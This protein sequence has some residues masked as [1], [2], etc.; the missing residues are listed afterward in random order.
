MKSLKQKSSYTPLYIYNMRYDMSETKSYLEVDYFTLSFIMIYDNFTLDFHTSNEFA[1][2][3][4]FVYRM[5][6]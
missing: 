1:E 4:H 5:Y 2:M 6:N 3:K